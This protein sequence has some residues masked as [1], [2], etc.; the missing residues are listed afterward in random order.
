MKSILIKDTTKYEFLITFWNS[1]FIR[2]KSFHGH[3]KIILFAQ[4]HDFFH[5]RRCVM[6]VYCFLIFPLVD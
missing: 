4:A 1:A 5:H 2:Q 3:V 6:N